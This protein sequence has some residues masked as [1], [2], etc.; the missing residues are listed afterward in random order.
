MELT[1]Y[2]RILRKSWLL[3]LAT[4]LVLVAIAAAWSLTRTPQYEAA[5]KVFVSAQGGTSIGDLQQ[6]STFTQSRLAAYVELVE[7]P[8]VLD[9][10]IEILDL[11]TTAAELAEHVTAS[12]PPDTPIITITVTDPDPQTAADIS[13]AIAASLTASVV[14]LETLPTTGTSPVKLTAVA[15]AL[16][17]DAP[18]TPNV[19]LTLALA[20]VLGLALG[21]GVG[22]LRTVLDNR[23]RMPRH[24]AEVTDHPLIGSIPF[25]A[26]AKRRPIILQA[27]P[28]DPRSEA[29]RALRTNLQ[30]LDMDGGHSFVVTSSVS[31]E[32]KTTTAVNLAIALSDAGKRVV[33]IDADLRKPKVAE[34]MQIEGA[35]G[36]TD[37]LIGRAQLE[38]VLLPWG[39]LGLRV[40]P[41][42][43]V[44]PNPSELLGSPQMQQ[45]ITRLAAETDIILLDAPPLLP[46]TD[47]AVIA[48]RA[49]GAIVVVAAGSTTKHQL[50][51]AIGILDGVDARVSGVVLTMLPTRGADAYGYGYGYGYGETGRTEG[52][53]RSVA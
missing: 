51:N 22:V 30:F 17:A 49:T 37:V 4:V 18:A 5:S 40:L 32:G 23:V 28:H 50:K 33:L 16:P 44:P 12:A 43:P 41:A 52:D 53:S 35:A 14:E 46:V 42:G 24:V 7:T 36:L 1:D 34:Y 15:D 3:I 13:N 45:L 39:R 10:V 2:I 25:D 6:G 9:P 21:I 27:S 47:A 38:D 29:F 48:A 31:S 20:A 26:D 19:P 11:D 8:T